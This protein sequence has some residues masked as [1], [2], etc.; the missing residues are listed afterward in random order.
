MRRGGPHAF[1]SMHDTGSFLKSRI[2]ARNE[3]APQGIR[4]RAPEH[5]SCGDIGGEDD[6]R[7]RARERV[8]GRLPGK[9]GRAAGSARER[10]TRAP[11]GSRRRTT[12]GVHRR[13]WG[14]G[15]ADSTATTTRSTDPR[16]L[17]SDRSAARI[18][19]A[20]TMVA[21]AC[22]PSICGVSCGPCACSDANVRVKWPIPCPA[23]SISARS[24]S[25]PRRERSDATAAPTTALAAT[26]STIASS[27]GNAEP[28]PSPCAAILSAP[29]SAPTTVP[30]SCAAASGPDSTPRD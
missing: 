4:R 21:A 23:A 7:C 15:G 24:T 11:V 9:S 17:S 28:P 27:P 5:G 6:G 18:K 19:T 22:A 14:T 30:R 20:P 3:R 2:G 12:V 1:G 26:S 25:G 8:T 16:R 29:D 13:M 10:A